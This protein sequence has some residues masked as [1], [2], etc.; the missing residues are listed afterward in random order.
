[1]TGTEMELPATLKR[2]EVA[3]F[4]PKEA[5]RRDVKADAVIDYA[6][7]VK[8]WP[9]LETA[10]KQ[11]LEDQAEFVR[12]WGETVTPNKGGDRKNEEFQDQY[13]RARG[14]CGCLRWRRRSGWPGVGKIG[15]Q[16]HRCGI[17][18]CF[19][20]P[21]AT[22]GPSARSRSQHNRHKTAISSW[23]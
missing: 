6:K 23:K 1:M 21:I 15:I 16:A 2:T 22:P 17:P 5:K 18:E 11:K 14:L 3:A 4:K 7:K 12:W 8:D 9:A 20:T 13:A 10:V 19:V